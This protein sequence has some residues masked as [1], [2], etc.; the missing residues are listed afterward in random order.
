LELKPVGIPAF[1]FDLNGN[2]RQSQEAMVGREMAGPY[3]EL[4][5]YQLVVNLQGLKVLKLNLP[6]RG[7]GAAVF[8]GHPLLG[9]PQAFQLA[10]IVANEIGAGGPG[11]QRQAQG[12]VAGDMAKAHTHKMLVCGPEIELKEWH[13]KS[14]FRR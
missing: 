9:N 12:G 11:R 13:R 2:G 7:T 5:S 10:H 14:G 4:G 6:A 3:A 8:Q 1:P